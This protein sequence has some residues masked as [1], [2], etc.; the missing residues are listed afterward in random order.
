MLVITPVSKRRFRL[1]KCFTRNGINVPSGFEFDGA[2]IPRIFWSIFAP[3]EYLTS[4][5][6]HDFGYARAIYFY[7]RGGYDAARDWFKKA[8]TAFLAALKEDDRRV[9]RLF[10]NAVRFY[11]WVKYPKAR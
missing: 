8:D 3:H 5:V 2:S 7:E 4:S 1:V 9:A 10:Y 6:I 11:R